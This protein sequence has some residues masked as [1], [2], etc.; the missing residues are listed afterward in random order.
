MAAGYD[1]VGAAITVSVALLLVIWPKG[2]V[3]TQLNVV[4]ESANC[5]FGKV[6]ALLVA[7]RIAVVPFLYHWYFG[8]K[9]PRPLATTV[10]VGELPRSEEHTSELQSRF[11]ISY[12]VFCLKK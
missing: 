7:F 9:A 3:A 5:A 8:A 1:S 2:F 4:A 12:A 10:N 11:G 6:Y